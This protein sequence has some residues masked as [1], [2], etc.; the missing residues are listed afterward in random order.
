MTLHKLK[1]LRTMEFY[2]K[3]Y[4][5]FSN[6]RH[7]VWKSVKDF[8]D[9][10][11]S[12][13]IILDAGCGNG[14]NMIYIN[15]F[16]KNQFKKH[17]VG[18]DTCVNFVDLCKKKHL[19][20]NVGDVKN[21]KYASNS[22]DFILCIAVI[23]HLKTEKDRFKALQELLRVLKPGGKLLVTAW[24]YE[25]DIYSKKRQFQVGDNTVLFNGHPRY[26]H[27]YDKKSFQEYCNKFS[28]SKNIYWER[29]NWNALFE[30]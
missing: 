28:V 3:N 9:L 30:K 23:H 21:I 6:T 17:I 10:I 4:R 19:N 7:S 18:F 13:S 24:A 16:R 15:D 29:G 5:E 27:V 1:L 2:N 25:T 8:C 14:K 26:Y 22:F 12:E 11:K 20:V